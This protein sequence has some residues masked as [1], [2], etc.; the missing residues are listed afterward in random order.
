MVSLYNRINRQR[1]AY[2]DNNIIKDSFIVTQAVNG[3]LT[4]A[5]NCIPSEY[6]DV[7]NIVSHESYIE[8][9]NLLFDICY[10]ETRHSSE[11]I[12]AI[13]CEH[14]TYR[15]IN[16]EPTR[17][18]HQGAPREILTDILSGTEFS[19]GDVEFYGDYLFAETDS[20]NKLDQLRRFAYFIGG[21]LEYDGFTVH[22]R[23]LTNRGF[24]A[25]FGK[26]I[27]DIQRI[28]D[29]RKDA[30]YYKISLVDLSNHPLYSDVKDL[31]RV[32][33][34]DEIRIIDEEIGV[35][36]LQRIISRTYN[37]I[38]NINLSV[39]IANR[40]ELF[41]DTFAI[42]QRDIDKRFVEVNVTVD[43]LDLRLG[44][45]FF[46]RAEVDG[47][48]V[49]SEAVLR[50]EFNVGLSDLRFDVLQN[51]STTTETLGQ[52]AITE[53]RLTS[54]F[55]AGLSGFRYDLNETKNTISNEIDSTEQR[56]ARLILDLETG[57][58]IALQNYSTISGM[59]GEIASSEQRSAQLVLDLQSGFNV[60]LQNY[61]TTT[62]M[63]GAITTQA[64][65]TLQLAQNSFSVALQN[66]STTSQVNNSINST[67]NILRSE[68]TLTA[69]EFNT[70]VGNSTNF[71]QLRQTVDSINLTGFVTF[72]SL[73]APG[74]TTING[75]N[76]TTGTIN[77]AQ[78]TIT[79]LNADNITAGWIN[80]NRLAYQGYNVMSAS[81]TAP[82]HTLNIGY[83]QLAGG[84]GGW[85][86]A[87]TVRIYGTTVGIGSSS[88][89]P[90]TLQLYSSDSIL[91]SSSFDF[92]L[93]AQNGFYFYRNTSNTTNWLRI[94]DGSITVNGAGNNIG[95]TTARFAN[96]YFT[97][98]NVTN[99]T[100]SS[101]G[102]SA[103]RITNT[104][105]TNLD[106][107][108]IAGG[109]GKSIGSSATRFANGYF[110]TMYSTN[111]GAGTAVST[112]LYIQNIYGGNTSTS[113]IR[114]GSGTLAFFGANP[115]SRQTGWYN[116]TNTAWSTAERD[117]IN[118]I[119]T[120]LRTIG[121]TT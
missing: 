46:T 61:S 56:L 91:I 95:S 115:I 69:S 64:T 71:T 31:E 108:T 48:I 14:I 42:M 85:H 81:G 40:I 67:A 10:A 24:T 36:A 97:N 53:E 54:L 38:E 51:Y 118:A 12:Y 26:N 103:S 60:T 102:T 4:A 73:S 47:R 66:Y 76:I 16:R 90:S 109:A 110:T 99:F 84:T 105:L 55:N 34:G 30:V 116:L 107:T 33:D 89:M 50:S 22:L 94:S 104:F 100:V 106:V 7:G 117:R 18:S 6:I 25:R 27:I 35:N 49:T 13:E 82:S 21:K 83:S 28:I 72:S 120:F 65:A 86:T 87:G 15:L 20:Q 79:N 74:A 101:L 78:V 98:L 62:Q 114:L 52:I 77:A 80:I 8:V 2:L 5:F 113:S 57:F 19:A 3:E 29:N 39:E 43:G 9:G 37:P 92:R 59:L 88:M 70:R 44:R 121:L 41:T 1:T 32:Y 45:D 112:N 119:T 63:N 96:G 11:L 111:I 68:L 93:Y 17:F 58:A 75:G 23:K